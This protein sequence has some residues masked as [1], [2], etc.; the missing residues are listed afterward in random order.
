VVSL[1]GSEE[2]VTAVQESVPGR[3]LGLRAE[4]AYPLEAR[5]QPFG[6]E[7]TVF[8]DDDERSEAEQVVR[9]YGEPLW[10][11]WPLGYQNSA[12]LVCLPENCPNN[13]PPVFWSDAN[14]WQPLFRR[15]AR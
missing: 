14:G 8:S 10:S 6:P 3:A 7:S 1:V 5:N 4:L 15:T 2:G 13:V 12:A 9:A 11:A